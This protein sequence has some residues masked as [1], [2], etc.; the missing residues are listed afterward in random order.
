M[1]TP[2]L[3]ARRDKTRGDGSE[4]RIY[5]CICVSNTDKYMY[6]CTTSAHSRCF[7]HVQVIL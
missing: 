1:A 4:G 3:E 5:I 6:R 7:I 2:T